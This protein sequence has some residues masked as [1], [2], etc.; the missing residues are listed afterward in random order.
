MS[1]NTNHLGLI[2]PS[3]TDYYDIEVF[4][5]NADSIDGAIKGHDDRIA[6]I[7]N[8]FDM[9]NSIRSELVVTQDHITSVP[10]GT[11]SGGSV[12]I[13]GLEGL[14]V[15]QAL[16][17]G[18]FES[19]KNWSCP[20]SNMDA[21]ENEIIEIVDTP[22]NAARIEYVTDNAVQG[23]SY[24]V[25]GEILASRNANTFFSYG[26]DTLSPF[27]IIPGKWS[28]VYGILKPI[29]NTRLRFYHSTDSYAKGEIV[30]RRKVMVIPLSG[31]LKEYS[32][33]QLA[34][35]AMNSDYW[36]GIK[37]VLN[38][39]IL[40]CGKN[41]FSSTLNGYYLDGE[42]KYDISNQNVLKSKLAEIKPNTEY[43]V[44]KLKKV[45]DRFRV[46]QFSKKPN[47]GDI[48][49][50]DYTNDTATTY[51]FISEKNAR[52]V[53][54]YYTNTGSDEHLMLTV[55][56]EVP[57]TYDQYR[58]SDSEITG[59]FRSLPNGV[60]DSI[61][62]AIIDGQKMVRKVE[63][64]GH[65]YIDD[66]RYFD[67]YK[68]Y[69]NIDLIRFSVNWDEGNTS[70]VGSTFSDH[71][72]IN[73]DSAIGFENETYIGERYTAVADS[74]RHNFIVEE[75]TT[76]AEFMNKNRFKV[77]LYQ[78]AKPKYGEWHS[79]NPSS[80]SDGEIQ[81]FS[82]SGLIPKLELNFP[83]NQASV[84]NDIS[85]KTASH[86]AFIESLTETQVPPVILKNDRPTLSLD[87]NN[88]GVDPVIRGK[89]S[90]VTNLAPVKNGS[91]NGFSLA[92]GF[93]NTIEN[94]YFKETSNT[95]YRPYFDIPCG[96]GEDFSVQVKG[97]AS[98]GATY[99]Y[100]AVR[101]LDD[102]N[103][104]LYT[105]D[106][107][108]L[109]G[110]GVNISK[111]YT[112]KAPINTVKL[113]FYAIVGDGELFYKDID[114]RSGNWMD[115]EMVYVLG[116]QNLTDLA[117]DIR[118]VKN[119]VGIT[120]KGYYIGL[121]GIQAVSTG[122]ITDY[123]PVLPN[124][125]YITN[126]KNLYFGLYDVNKNFIERQGY[127][128]GCSTTSET[129]Y[130]VVSY[131]NSNT[132]DDLVFTEG[133]S[134]PNEHIESFHNKVYAPVTLTSKDNYVIEGGKMVVDRNV[135]V[136]ESLDGI[137]YDW[138]FGNT[139]VGFKRVKLPLSE[140]YGYTSFDTIC[141]K[142]NGKNIGFT[143]TST[144]PD[145]IGNDV[146]FFYISINNNDSGWGD[147]YTPTSDEIKAYMNG[148]VGY[149]TSTSS[150]IN[151]STVDANKRWSKRYQGIGTAFTT[152]FGAVIETGALIDYTPKE[153][154]YGDITETYKLQY[155]LAKPVRE[156]IDLFSSMTMPEGKVYATM[157]SG[158]RLEKVNP[159]LG[160]D[161]Y[162]KVNYIGSDANA[163]SAFN[164]KASSVL[165]WII[166][167]GDSRYKKDFEI[168]TSESA[169]YGEVHPYILESELTEHEA[170][171]S[172]V[173]YKTLSEENNI[174]VFNAQLTYTDDLINVLQQQ[175][176]KIVYQAK[177][178]DIVKTK[179][180]ELTEKVVFEPTLL[181]GCA[182]YNNAFP[183][184][185]IHDPIREE[186]R[187]I[188]K[189]IGYGTDLNNY[190]AKSPW[191]VSDNMR[192]PIT[193][194]A[195]GVGHLCIQNTGELFLSTGTAVGVTLFIDVSFSF[196]EKV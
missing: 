32:V 110:S 147:S 87:L 148:W 61:E 170:K 81:L 143:G 172:Y 66:L 25:Y 107:L 121:S 62:V 130:V 195:S 82:D 191:T 35:M 156:E 31:P 131:Y 52:W 175:G 154:A 123:I 150:Y 117:F 39:R 55:G 29:N 43:T 57:S 111:I 185:I 134:P 17:N 92:D 158:V 78:Y 16:D 146:S 1:T 67:I 164:K 137:D 118:S 104:I 113:R 14:S 106:K 180:K 7:E 167:D 99:G 3:P 41:K 13:C 160:I 133:I 108:I 151:S 71:I 30:K 153:K 120:R 177:Q 135:R 49:L 42:I 80:F 171:N 83:L 27:Q 9:K 96:E 73:T 94:G 64:V 28:P 86:Q 47:I 149:D 186:I 36:E 174:N 179:L 37:S 65:K 11:V 77:L 74:S 21:L 20:Y 183:L 97:F 10:E 58:S 182:N 54:V 190:I 142:Y 194:S 102:G 189:I 136:I 112:G 38:P 8:N 119:L 166:G 159:K 193:D 132:F 181:N 33:D 128:S 15:L 129:A 187:I 53:V 59:E 98:A 116:T 152:S 40:S 105:N 144:N 173:V 114:I 162:W 19:V 103:N 140:L 155:D 56:P 124:A 68:D 23:Q 22:D 69:Q 109:I 157:E 46:A 192:K 141:T 79:V 44:S 178:L 84:L 6:D 163:R 45:S 168:S 145:A 63:R 101:F 122:E 70:V 2:K 184:R 12:E 60:R 85:E 126:K 125:S 93:Y 48:P 138:Y 5:S 51:S 50:T 18:N 115:R 34:Y 169:S 161:G 176:E 196:I 24:F 26:G 75:G 91:W 127:G 165:E 72:E 76:Y 100:C 89:G 90:T 95:E 4:N 139:Y 188:G 88:G